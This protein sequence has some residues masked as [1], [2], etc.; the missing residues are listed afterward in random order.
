MGIKLARVV[1]GR[2]VIEHDPIGHYV[3]PWYTV[4]FRGA[5]FQGEFIEVWR[6]FDNIADAVADADR[7]GPMPSSPEISN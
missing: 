5:L 7:R 3:A 2:R 4:E 1:N 6:P